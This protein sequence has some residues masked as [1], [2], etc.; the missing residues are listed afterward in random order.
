MIF[1]YRG[2]HTSTPFDVIYSSGSHFAEAQNST[3]PNQPDITTATDDAMVVIFHAATHN[4]INTVGAPASYTLR[5]ESLIPGT[6]SWSKS[7]Q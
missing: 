3:T 2:V 1:S 6:Q 4:D 7:A 5:E